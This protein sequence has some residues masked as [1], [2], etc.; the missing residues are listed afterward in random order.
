MVASPLKAI[1]LLLSLS[2][3]VI[4]RSLTQPSLSFKRKAMCLYVDNKLLWGRILSHCR[5]Q[6]S[7]LLQMIHFMQETVF[8]FL[9][10]SQLCSSYIVLLNYFWWLCCH[11]SDV[12]PT[13]DALMIQSTFHVIVKSFQSQYRALLQALHSPP[14]YLKPRPGY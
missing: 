11:G 5:P 4:Y 8:F 3:C 12:G 6:S 13:A 10:W 14:T 9:S 2:V 1:L 7:L